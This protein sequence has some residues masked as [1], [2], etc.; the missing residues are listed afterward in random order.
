WIGYILALT[1]SAFPTSSA[2][3]RVMRAANP[4]HLSGVDGWVSSAL[5]ALRYFDQ[6]F[7]G[8]RAPIWALAAAI[9]AM[10]AVVHFR[11]AREP[12]GLGR[13][14]A[15]VGLGFVAWVAYYVID[16]GGFRIW[17]GLYLAIPVYVLCVPLL[18]RVIDLYIRN[19][20]LALGITAVGVL[21]FSLPSGSGPI[22]PHEYD[23]F[24]AALAANEVL[25]D[26]PETAK[27][28]SFNAGVYNFYTDREVI[29]LDGVV[30]PGA[31]A[32]HRDRDIA[33][34]MRDR[35]IEYLI[36]H[37]PTRSA[38]FRRVYHDPSL[39]FRRLIE[40]TGRPFAGRVFKRTWLWKV[41][42]PIDTVEGAGQALPFGRSIGRTRSPEPQV[43]EV[44]G[45]LPSS[46]DGTVP[47]RAPAHDVYRVL[48]PRPGREELREFARVLAIVDQL[49]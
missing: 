32:A 9:G 38:T 4:M 48:S 19:D 33:G 39:R 18:A 42:Y 11:P 23:K 34:Y 37:D 41:S 13:L 26:L 3:L 21:A 2:A 30:N 1:G 28:G 8:G 35:G 20:R 15:V 49:L 29:N 5:V 6:Y 43:P 27:I 24:Q 44:V 46:Q 36:E 31:L 14:A 10:C 16:L 40:L 7:A 12:S 22:A 47:G 45:N 25:R 17:Y